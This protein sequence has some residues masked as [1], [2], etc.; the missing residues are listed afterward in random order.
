MDALYKPNPLQSTSP[1]GDFNLD[2]VPGELK[3]L[4]RWVNWRAVQRK[5]KATKIP[6]NPTNGE[7]ASCADPSTWGTYDQAVERLKLEGING[8]GFQLGAGFGG[9]DLD[10]CRNPETGAIECWAKEIIRSLNSYSEISPSRTGVHILVKGGLPPGPR[11]KGNI[12]MYW[13]GRFF[14]ITGWHVEGTPCTI[15]ERSHAM[16]AL[17]QQEL[18]QTNYGRKTFGRTS[19][20]GNIINDSDLIKRACRAKNGPKFCRLWAGDLAGYAS[21]SEADLALCTILAFWTARDEVRI[22]NLFRQSG[23]FRSKWDERHGA[24][25]KT[26]GQITIARAVEQTLEVWSPGGKGHRPPQSEAGASRLPVILV[27]DRQLREVTADALKALVAGN[28]PP[29]LFVRSGH[30][31][32]IQTDETGRSAIQVLTEDQLRARL[33]EISNTVRSSKDGIR[34]CFPPVPLIENILALHAWSFPPLQAITG[35]PVLRPDGTLLAKPGYDSATH[36]FYSPPSEL[37]VPEIPTVLSRKYVAD[38]LQLITEPF[39]EFPFV[40]E[41]GLP[42]TLGTAL[43]PILRFAIKGSTPLGLFD[44]PQAGTGKGLL[45]ELIASITTGRPAAMMAAPHQEEEWR[46]RITAL[47]SS[48]A[49]VITIDNVENRLESASLAIALTAQEWTDRILGLS[50]V[51]TCPVR[52]TWVATGNNIRLGGDLPRRC[53]WIRL[54]SKMSRPWKRSGFKHPDLLAWVSEHRGELLVALLTLA[55]AWYAA[56]KPQASVPVI[57]SF[58]EWANTVGG[59][60]QYAGMK[61]FL[62]NLE[63]MYEF[64]DESALQWE[65]FLQALAT[66]FSE[67]VFTVKQVTEHVA[68]DRT[69][70]ETLPDDVADEA[71]KPGRFQRRLGRALSRRVG[72]RYGDRGIHL[73]RAGQERRATRWKVSIG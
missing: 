34:D 53:Y 32:R 42:N 45:A 35:V 37:E 73:E 11:R 68:V 61:G 31:V 30:L 55:R 52:V 65:A 63:E 48:G 58:T 3:K 7:P 62:G 59:I 33:T 13:Q 21:Q 29:S 17:H 5:G 20:V 1:P 57:G 38:A 28:N 40:D 60:L 41:A 70:A 23:L 66:A 50:K 24:D 64:S 47:L 2:L 10:I 16:K 43:T 14:T 72:T 49:T 18:S 12:E 39:R 22:D 71:E 6:I 4:K 25:G 15:E 9:V 54:D 51:I 19:T 67:G 26:Y 56:D 46:K 44:A 69:L 36:L 8:I 27:N